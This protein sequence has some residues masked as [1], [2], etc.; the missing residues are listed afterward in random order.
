MM[1]LNSK[2]LQ[3][4]LLIDFVKYSI[5]NLDKT[6]ELLA[7][8]NTKNDNVNDLI[9]IERKQ[10]VGEFKLYEMMSENEKQLYLKQQLRLHIKTAKQNKTTYTG[11]N[12]N[13]LKLDY[14]KKSL[15]FRNWI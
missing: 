14:Q 12:R 10:L 2:H 6:I 5:D 4:G 13:F 11:K 3:L 7:D 9:E 8:L 15:I 1:R